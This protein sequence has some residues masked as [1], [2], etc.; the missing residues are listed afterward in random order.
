MKS[1]IAGLFLVS[2]S[3]VLFLPSCKKDTKPDRHQ[4]KLDAITQSKAYQYFFQKHESA[5]NGI[6]YGAARFVSLNKE[7]ESLHIPVYR[8]NQIIA[9]VIGLP[10]G[11]GGEYE[12]IFQDNA[13]ALDGTGTILQYAPMGLFQKI[14]IVENKMVSIEQGIYNNTAAGTDIKDPDGQ[15]LISQNDACGFFCRMD[16]CYNATKA[17]FPGD[18]V[19]SLLDMFFG[20]CTSATVTSCLIKMAGGQY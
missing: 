14:N 6:D 13:D 10:A 5:L 20:V 11:Y 1:K 8:N 3:F 18:T 4:N 17:Q 16:K 7:L 2:L 19:C 9:A 12:F 15:H